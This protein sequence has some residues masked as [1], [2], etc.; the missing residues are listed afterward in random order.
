MS[1]RLPLVALAG[2]I[3][4]VTAGIWNLRKSPV[5]FATL[6]SWMCIALFCLVFQGKFYAYHWYPLYP[7]AIILAVIGFAT[8][9]FAATQLSTACLLYLF[10]LSMPLL[11]TPVKETWWTAQ[12]S[13]IGNGSAATAENRFRPTT[14]YAAARVANSVTAEGREARAVSIAAAR[15]FRSEGK[16][17]ALLA[18][19]RDRPLINLVGAIRGSRER[20]VRS[21]PPRGRIHR[22]TQCRRRGPAT[23]APFRRSCEHPPRRECASDR[24]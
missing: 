13:A 22:R 8:V 9:S 4:F 2:I 17:S 6:I 10:A 1:E 23:G 24:P 15:L 7:P 21:T 3:P 20:G 14:D 16:T 5:I 12:C 11:I 18:A 19:D